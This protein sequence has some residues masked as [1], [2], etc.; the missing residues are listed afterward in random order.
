MNEPADPRVEVID[1]KP[2]YEG[3]FRIDA[4]TLRHHT[5]DGGWSPELRVELFERGQTAVVLPY[6]PERDSVVLIEQFR[7]GAYAGGR[8]PWMI[9]AVAG[10]IEDGETAVVVAHREAMEEAGCKLT[11][12]EPIGTFL[13]SPGACSE[14]C[15][16]FVG[17]VD[18]QGVGGIHGLAEEGEDI[19]VS[20]VAADE[21]VARVLGGEILSVYGAIPLLWLA[22]NRDELRARWL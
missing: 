6:D 20:V 21:A 1:R 2:V 18:S 8:D 19:Q 12:L 5:Y 13:L 14:A 22:L 16:M 11:E 4:Y 15:A 17:R 3:F 7:I 10:T 9:E